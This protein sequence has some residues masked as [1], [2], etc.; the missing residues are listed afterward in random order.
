[1]SSNSGLWEKRA[2]DKVGARDHPLNSSQTGHLLHGEREG[3][4]LFL[5]SVAPSRY[6]RADDDWVGRGSFLFFF[7][8]TLFTPKIV[9]AENR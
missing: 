6:I 8:S 2:G 9:D 7:L 1:M 5:P 4:W 3:K